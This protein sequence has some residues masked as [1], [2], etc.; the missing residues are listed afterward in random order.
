[1]TDKEKAMEEASKKEIYR[2]SEIID[3]ITKEPDGWLKDVCIEL[4]DKVNR[5]EV[6]LNSMYG[7]LKKL[8]KEITKKKGLI[9]IYACKSQKDDKEI[10]RMHI[11]H[12]TKRGE[13]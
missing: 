1:M 10:A 3:G 5:K 7:R 6:V 13:Q 9:G 2:L 12:A 4:L 8:E 11:K